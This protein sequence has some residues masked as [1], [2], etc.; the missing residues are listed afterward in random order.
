MKNA[1]AIA[2]YGIAAF[3]FAAMSAAA[4][5]LKEV[6][7][8]PGKGETRVVFDLAC[9]PDYT[10]SG[11]DL[12][13]GRV[14]IDFEGLSVPP[15]ALAVQSGMGHVANYQFVSR[16]QG[17]VRA[18]L[19][20][21]KSAKVKEVFIIEPS[22]GVS[23]YRLVVDF[24]NAD[25]TAFLDSIPAKYPDLGPVIERATAAGADEVKPATMQKE[26]AAPP[27]PPAKP[28]KKVIVVDAGHGGGDPGSQGQNGTLEKTVTMKAALTLKEILEKSDRYKVVLTRSADNDKRVRSS[29]REEL[30]RREALARDADADLFI[31]LHADAIGDKV[32]R[33]GSVYT[34]SDKG[35]ARS[36]KIA[37]SEGN[38]VVYDLNAADF[39]AGVSDI[40]FDLAQGA[41]S[42]ESNRF[43]ELLID[44]LAGKTKLLNRTHRTGDLRVLL[45]PDVPAV[46]FEM[47]FISN[48][49]DEANLNSAAWRARTMGAVAK[50]I[51]D[52]FDEEAAQFA[53][54]GGGAGR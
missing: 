13:I 41:T 5:D 15:A 47:A 30:A 20:L 18:V 12:G 32:T 53:Q 4:A 33:G 42:K 36:A 35:S 27:Q 24:Q 25:K 7:F 39:G 51:D 50:A 21:K 48:A 1:A 23:K 49:K 10:L 54:T 14:F 11:D 31:S 26:V 29:Q 40:L 43:A 22:A 8:G 46:L 37:K 16:G 2:V 6:R 19:T 9:A 52:Y 38:Y 28:E 45:A 44:E 34:L 17:A 3:F